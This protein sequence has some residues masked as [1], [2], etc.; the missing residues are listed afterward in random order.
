MLLNACTTTLSQ[1]IPPEMIAE[2]TKPKIASVI[3][4]LFFNFITLHKK[5]RWA[6]QMERIIGLYLEY[7][8]TNLSFIATS[9]G[10][11]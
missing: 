9:N 8:N 1:K 7:V 5:S 2:M 11:W 3:K 6:G 4:N 10:K